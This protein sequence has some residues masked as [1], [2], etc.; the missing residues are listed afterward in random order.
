MG[1]S[2]ADESGSQR[3]NARVNE[4]SRDQRTENNIESNGR[5]E[6]MFI[7]LNSRPQR[8]DAQPRTNQVPIFSAQLILSNGNN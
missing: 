5:I 2:S 3:I 4:K 8:V 6:N 7:D 1:S